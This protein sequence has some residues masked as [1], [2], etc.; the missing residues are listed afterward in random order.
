MIEG[1]FGDGGRLFFE[2]ELITTDGL[3]LPVDTL[4][5]TGFTGFMAINKQ[6]LQGLNWPFISKEKLRTAQ[7]ESR[8]D[9]YSG[10]VI[11][12]NQEYKIPVYA[13]DEL[14]EILLGS[15]WLEFLPL[16]VNFQ[17]SILTLG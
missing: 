13:G 9:L 14:T 8:F 12:D 6:D 2:V 1:Y 5:D 15:A 3:N 16:V 4:F 11:L 10:K 7:G 17:Q